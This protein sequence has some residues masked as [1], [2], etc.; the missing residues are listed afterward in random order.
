MPRFVKRKDIDDVKWNQLVADSVLKQ[1][2][3]NTWYLDTICEKWDALIYG[4]YEFILPIA[5]GKKYLL[6]YAY[7]PYFTQNFE[8]H[9]KTNVPDKVFL[10]FI[11]KLKEKYFKLN[12]C[13]SNVPSMILKHVNL[14]ERKRQILDLNKPYKELYENYSSSHKRNIKKAQKNNLV[15]K[16]IPLSLSERNFIQTFYKSRK[17]KAEV[18]LD[19]YFRNIEVLKDNNAIQIKGVFEDDMLQ[20]ITLCKKIEPNRYA[21]N[22][23]NNIQG[24]RNGA[25]F[26]VIDDLIKKMAKTSCYLDFE[27][28]NISS[29]RRRNIGFGGQDEKY[30]HL[31]YRKI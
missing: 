19:Y 25:A 5:N 18:A 10:A 31:N 2:S 9:G 15:I 29:I 21:I 11:K 24:A 16:D 6:S 27:G 4:D 28:S 22:S 30:Y 3:V 1:L 7:Q 23:I 14:Q 20:N 12:L 26:Y 17:I 13:F 8:I